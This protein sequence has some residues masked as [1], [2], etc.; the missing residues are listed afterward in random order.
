MSLHRRSVVLGPGLALI[1]GLALAP[2]PASGQYTAVPFVITP[3]QHTGISAKLVG[4]SVRAD[5]GFPKENLGSYTPVSGLVILNYGRL[6]ASAGLGALAN[7]EAP[8]ELTFGGSLGWD[9]AY[10][11][12][13]LPTITLQAAAG[14]TTLSVEPDALS[15]WDIPIGLG[16]SLPV[17][18]P[19]WPVNFEP[20]LA[21]RSH[22]RSVETVASSTETDVGF[23]LS[24]G[25]RIMSAGQHTYHIGVHGAFDWLWIKGPG[26]DDLENEFTA[27]V[28]L[29]LRWNTIKE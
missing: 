8:D 19:N 18:P 13:A 23:G 10:T 4:V 7:S 24:T 12:A 5:V 9:I 15:L 27:S 16:G 2:A 6:S 22:I 14:Y 21:L 29:V 20:W 25:L 26:S 11:R 17:G 28:G 3:N 1:V